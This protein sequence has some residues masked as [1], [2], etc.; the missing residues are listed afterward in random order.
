MVR[1]ATLRNKT[2][3]KHVSINACQKETG[4][5]VGEELTYILLKVVPPQFGH[6][7][8][9]PSMLKWRR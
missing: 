1:F 7:L 6:F 2:D 9:E 4:A 3:S 8:H 5:R